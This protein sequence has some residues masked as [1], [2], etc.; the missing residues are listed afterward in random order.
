MIISPFVF[1][2]NLFPISAQFQSDSQGSTDLSSSSGSES[3]GS[4]YNSGLSESDIRIDGNESHDHDNLGGTQDSG[5]F[6]NLPLSKIFIQKLTSNTQESK[7]SRPYHKPNS[8]HQV[9]K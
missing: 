8:V 2:A 3:E 5:K 7:P 4:N 6:S 9:D 1:G